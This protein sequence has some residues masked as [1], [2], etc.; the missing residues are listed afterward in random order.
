M[1]Y[2]FPHAVLSLHIGGV[3]NEVERPQKKK[4]EEARGGDRRER[5]GGEKKGYQ[6]RAQ[7]YILRCPEDT[8]SGLPLVS[9]SSFAYHY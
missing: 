5:E 8:R 7:R 2:L 1:S 9:V 6:H 4:G 3:K